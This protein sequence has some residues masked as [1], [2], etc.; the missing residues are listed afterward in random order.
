[1]R[2]PNELITVSHNFENVVT[3]EEIP[4]YDG[5]CFDLNDPKQ[6]EKFLFF[7]ERVVRGSFEYKRLIKYLKETTDM[8]QSTFFENLSSGIGSKVKIE[9]HHDPFDLFTICKIVYR[10]RV[11]YGQDLDEESIAEEVTWLHYNMLIGLVPLTKTE[12]QLVHGQYLFVPTTAVFGYYKRFVNMYDQW[13][14]EEEKEVLNLIENITMNN[15][16]EENPEVLSRNFIF[17]DSGNTYSLSEVQKISKL[18]ENSILELK[19]KQD[20]LRNR[21]SDNKKPMI[22]LFIKCDDK[23]KK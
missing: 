9:I 13:I 20:N 19:A 7:V 2:N 12:H 14:S 10:K 5:N 16:Y 11:S 17:L 23:K 6:L 4:E 18:L 8:N 21:I 1:M 3:L 15:E 22:K